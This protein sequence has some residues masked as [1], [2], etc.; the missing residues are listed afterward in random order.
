M[1]FRYT[2]KDQAGKSVSGTV[3]AGDKRGAALL[4]REQK[5]TPLVIQEKKGIYPAISDDDKCRPASN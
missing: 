4:V 1:K 2:A 5:M 3:E